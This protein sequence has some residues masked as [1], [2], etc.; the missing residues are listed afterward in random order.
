MNN[1]N[2]G[3]TIEGVKES[4]K[5]INA[6]LDKGNKAGAYSLDEAYVA[7][8]AL[9][10]LNQAVT[11]LEKLGSQGSQGSKQSP[12]TADNLEVND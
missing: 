5:M 2:Q 4:L 12:Q 6:C 11:A 9:N 3:L 7:K 1:S 8:V 10:N